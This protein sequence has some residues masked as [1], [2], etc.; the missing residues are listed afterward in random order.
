VRDDAIIGLAFA[1]FFEDGKVIAFRGW[2]NLAHRRRTL[3]KMRAFLEATSRL[4]E[5]R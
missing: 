3:A 5:K 2:D 4:E 1:Q